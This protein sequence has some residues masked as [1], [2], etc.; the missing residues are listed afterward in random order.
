MATRNTI[1]MQDKLVKA[2]FNRLDTIFRCNGYDPDGDKSISMSDALDIPQ[3]AFLIPKVLTQ[4]VQEGVEPMLIGTSLLQEIEYTPG[5]H[6]VFPAF[7]ILTAREV[8]DG[9][10]LPI[11]QINVG[12]GTTYGVNVKRH[13]LQLRITDRFI[14]NSTYPWMQMWM[15]MAGAALARHKEEY[16]FSFIRSLGTI[17]FDNAVAPRTAGYAGPKPMYGATTGRDVQGKYNGS[18]TADDLFTMYS[19]VLMQGFIPDTIL[20]HPL[21]WMVFMRDPVM[22]EFAREAGGG[23]FFGQFNG[24]AAAQAYKGFYN[25]KGLGQGLGQTQGN[26]HGE[27]DLPQN[28]NSSFQIPGYANF[29]NLR[30]LVSPFLRFDTNTKQT[31]IIMFNSQ[32]LG[33]LIVDQP[34][35]VRSWD[36]PGYDIQNLGIEESY[37]FGVLNEGQAIAVARNVSVRANAMYPE[38]RPFISVG[39]DNPNYELPVNLFGVANPIDVSANRDSFAPQGFVVTN[40]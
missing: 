4:I 14:E 13:G 9:A 17:V 19:Q 27:A 5:M 10:A 12:G 30:I 28:Q 35:H 8:G 2:T 32:N 21:T 16:I 39:P 29:G 33:A 34:P 3:A 36:E 18:F 20:V 31:D 40:S 7:D 23:S 11:F 37:G 15:R 24:N 6:T 25:N 26:I 22:R 1:D 38:A